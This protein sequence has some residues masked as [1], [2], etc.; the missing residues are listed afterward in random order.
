MLFFYGFLVTNGTATPSF[1]D[2]WIPGGKGGEQCEDGGSY[3]SDYEDV[4]V[5]MIIE[6]R[7]LKIKLILGSRPTI[8]K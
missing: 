8:Q 3:M 4:N 7:M 5:L 6:N 1:T 2:G